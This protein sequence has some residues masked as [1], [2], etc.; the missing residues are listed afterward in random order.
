[1][2]G[3]HLRFRRIGCSLYSPRS[4]RENGP[5]AA[6]VSVCRAAALGEATRTL[7]RRAPHSAGGPFPQALGNPPAGC[8]TCFVIL[9]YVSIMT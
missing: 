1:M 2:L 6:F 8:E 3:T 5:D 9:V 4:E 7:C